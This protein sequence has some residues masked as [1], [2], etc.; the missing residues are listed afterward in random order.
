MRMRP[1]VSPRGL[2]Q[3]AAKAWALALL[4]VIFFLGRSAAAQGT[5]QFVGRVADARGEVIPGATV[6]IHNEGTGVDVVVQATS[7]GDYTAPYMSPAN[8]RLRPN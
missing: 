7:V 6:T 8:T 3:S 1:A 2:K 5:Q 4:L